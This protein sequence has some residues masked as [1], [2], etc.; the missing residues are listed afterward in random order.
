MAKLFGVG[1]DQVGLFAQQMTESDMARARANYDGYLKEMQ[2]M[3]D[4]A[5]EMYGSTTRKKAEEAARLELTDSTRAEQERQMRQMMSAQS[6]GGAVSSGGAN[7]IYSAAQGNLQSGLRGITQDAFE[8]E[9]TAANAY[10]DAMSEVADRDKEFTD[11]NF[12]S[13]KEFMSW[14]MEMFPDEVTGINLVPGGG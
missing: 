1:V 6:R 3:R 9:Q 13:T 14:L 10:R 12:T 5:N 8:R 2:G 4:K 11:Q 7:S